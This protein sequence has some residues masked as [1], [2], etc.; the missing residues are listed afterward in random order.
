MIVKQGGK[1]LNIRILHTAASSGSITDKDGRT[2]SAAISAVTDIFSN[3]RDSS[4]TI[5]SAV[6]MY[7]GT[8]AEAGSAD[9]IWLHNTTVTS[10]G[11]DVDINT[12]VPCITCRTTPYIK[13]RFLG[14]SS[15]PITNDGREPPTINGVVTPV[16]S[17]QSGDVAGY[18][19]S[20][21]M[22]L[23]SLWR[24]VNSDP[25]YEFNGFVYSHT[26]ENQDTE[27]RVIREVCIAARLSNQIYMIAREVIPPKSLQPGQ[28]ITFNFALSY[29]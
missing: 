8:S 15:T 14:V 2:N 26:F 4:Y 28:T 22:W 17:L 12:L 9:D 13:T 23:G 25:S 18:E 27:T 21:F 20:V 3:A 29:T 7:V 24:Y 16:S 10:G 11:V 5:S 1:L 6:Y 19:G